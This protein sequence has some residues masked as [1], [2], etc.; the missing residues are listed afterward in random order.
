MA[1]LYVFCGRR[2][3]NSIVGF[4]RRLANARGIRLEITE[5]DIQR[6]RKLDLIVPSIQKNGCRK[7]LKAGILQSL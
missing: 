3:R 7:L 2:R 5:L 1:V 4:L 6:D